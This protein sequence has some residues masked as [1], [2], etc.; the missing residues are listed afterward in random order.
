[1]RQIKRFLKILLL[2]FVFIGPGLNG[3]AYGKS[4]NTNDQQITEGSNLPAF[5]LNVPSDIKMQEY[6]GVK[7]G[8]NFTLNQMNA[9][10]ILVDILS[11]L[12][13]QCHKNA[14]KVNRLFNIIENDPQL[15]SVKLFGLAFGDNSKLVDAYVQKYKVRF[16]I[17]PD[18]DDEI[19]DLFAGMGPPSIVITN[20]TGKVL[21]IHEGVIEDID[22]VMEEI[23][24]IYSQQ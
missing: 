5:T 11:V 14:P 4:I 12:C 21:F 10:L 15:H 13:P 18:P 16:P 8:A 7:N 22:F 2:I 20:K 1:M 6:L 23:R 24:S 3:P 9:K 17:F 19:G